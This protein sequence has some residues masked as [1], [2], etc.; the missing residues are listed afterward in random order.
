MDA[1]HYIDIF[2]TKGIEYLLVISYLLLLIF[3]WK[4]LN[5]PVTGKPVEASRSSAPGEKRVYRVEWFFLPDDR[6]FHQGHSWA[7]PEKGKFVRIGIDDFASRLLG[8]PVSI[9]LPRVGSRV[10]QGEKAWRLQVDSQSIE[11]LSPVSGTVTEINQEVLQSPEIIQQDPYQNGWLIRVKDNRLRTD[12][13]NLFHGD[14]AVLWTKEIV[15]RL[16]RMMSDDLGIVLQDGGLPVPGFVKI[17]FPK[18]WDKIVRE[19]FLSN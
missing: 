3:F 15:S 5:K 8:K 6:Y 12:V 2:A 7:L 17:I 9:K 1:Y 14:L 16:R 11:M 4:L 10:R 19:F 18:N 13:K